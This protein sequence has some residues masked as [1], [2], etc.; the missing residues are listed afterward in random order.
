MRCSTCFRLGRSHAA[1]NARLLFVAA[2]TILGGCAEAEDPYGRLSLS[3]TIT[4]QGEPLDAGVID[5]L[6]TAS[7]TTAGARAMI[8]DG[9]YTVPS[10][11]GL[12]PGVYRVVIT[13]A[14]DNS[15]GPPVGPPG[16]EMPPLGVERIPA[17]FNTA[18]EKTVE[19]TKSGDNVFDF[20]IP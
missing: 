3:G 9:S 13:S 10:S 19:A 1:W 5:F 8:Q 15:T 7:D 4:F 11:Q 16:M 2:L 17:E 18:S 14:E 12:M 6:P 20:T